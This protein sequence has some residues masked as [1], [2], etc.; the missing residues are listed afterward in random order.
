MRTPTQPGRRPAIL[1]ACIALA[2]TAAAFAFMLSVPTLRAD[3]AAVSIAPT[4]RSQLHGVH[5]SPQTLAASG[6][7]AGAVQGIVSN[8]AAHLEAHGPA[9]QAARSQA[10]GHAATIRGLERKQRSRTITPAEAATLANARTSLAAARTALA[11]GEDALFTAALA[12]LTADQQGRLSQI[13]GNADWDVPI[14]YKAVART[15][16]QWVAL[17]QALANARIASAQDTDPD[18]DCADLI[19]DCTNSYHVTLAAQAVT[20]NLDAIT[21]A[22]NNAS[23]AAP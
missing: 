11:N 17:R 18:Q 2:G 16:A 20:L 7:V 5:I 1:A 23:E 8:A 22:W 12:G 19:S 21:A 6:V 3:A 10:G 15:E 14:Q 9:L 13:R 4:V